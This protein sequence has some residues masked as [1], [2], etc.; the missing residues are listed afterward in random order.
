MEM[1]ITM[2]LKYVSVKCGVI[3]VVSFMWKNIM[4]DT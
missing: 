1:L 4:V 2:L 3:N